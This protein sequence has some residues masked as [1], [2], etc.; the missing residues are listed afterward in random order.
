MDGP[1]EREEDCYLII[2]IMLT[3]QVYYSVLIRI[4][5]KFWIKLMIYFYKT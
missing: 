5:Y 1:T 3:G 4:I 2:T